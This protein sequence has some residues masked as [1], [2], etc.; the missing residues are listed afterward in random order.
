MTQ[1][2]MFGPSLSDARVETMAAARSPKGTR[3]PLCSKFV[4]VY[5]RK[6]NAGMAL[7]LIRLYHWSRNHPGQYVHFAH[8]LVT[9]YR[10]TPGDHGKLAWWG[11]VEKHTEPPDDGRKT[12][13]LYRL[14]PLGFEFAEKRA[15]VRSHAIEYLSE[16]EAF[17]GNLI[18]I[19]DALG[20]NFNYRELMRAAPAEALYYGD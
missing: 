20:R 2:E 19:D 17:S 8:Y 6:F 13:G 18:D 1:Y 3:C 16:V 5:R 11:M 14:T 12:N 9:C 7:D 4:K 15:K 10:S